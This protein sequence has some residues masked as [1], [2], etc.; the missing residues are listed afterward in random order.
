MAADRCRF[1][2]L[3]EFEFFFHFPQGLFGNPVLAR[4][5]LFSQFCLAFEVFEKVSFAF[6]AAVGKAGERVEHAKV[7]E[8]ICGEGFTKN[9][10]ANVG[11]GFADLGG[12][13]LLRG[14]EAVQGI[15]AA[16]LGE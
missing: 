5:F 11:N 6:D 12:G 8:R 1:I 15:V 2:G 3:H 7:V 16:K 9:I 10:R 14:L 13:E 4:R